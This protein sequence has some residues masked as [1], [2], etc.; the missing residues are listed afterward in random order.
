[1]KLSETRN[2]LL[3]Q[4]IEEADNG[5]RL[6]SDPEKRLA[7]AAAGAPLPQ[8]VSAAGQNAFIAKRAASCLGT[9]E[10]RLKGDPAWI[11][12]NSFRSRI[13]IFTIVLLVTAAIVGYL[14]N[15]LNSDE[16]RINLL[17]FPLIGIL[18]WNFMIYLIEIFNLFQKHDTANGVSG[19]ICRALF[20]PFVL[21]KQEK[22]SGTEF[23]ARSLFQSRWR[24]INLAPI[25]ARVKA[26]LHLTALILAAAAIA[27]MYVKGVAKEYRAHWE[28]TFFENGAQLEPFLKTVLGPAAKVLSN[29]LP[30][31]AELDKLKK[32]NNPQGDN[33]ARWIHW[34]AVT[35]TLFVLS[36]RLLLGIF[37][38]FRAGSLDRAMPFREISPAYFDRILALATGDSLGIAIVP[39]AHKPGDNVLQGIRTYMEN[40]FRRPATIHW[41]KDIAF[42]EEEEAVVEIPKNLQPM[43]LF[44]FASTPEKE[45]HLAL[46][47]RLSASLP[48]NSRPYHIILDCEAFDRKSESFNDADERRAAR[49]ESWNKLFAVENCE[50][51]T[52]SDHTLPVKEK[53]NG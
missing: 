1:M 19:M 20:P 3:A 38:H 7:D 28:S 8:N 52:I 44:N 21:K 13:G 12:S 29:Q 42:G 17:S 35:I 11:R 37:W 6:L 9:I 53:R 36:P 33:A 18:A 50:I 16:S 4:A 10:P 48:E 25:S 41:F 51:H 24:Q 39:Y 40:T 34:Y 32:S 27:G 14:T 47:K 49:L 5:G 30:D 23:R 45:T 26:T 2:I 15:E 31:G 46:Y 43:L 22:E